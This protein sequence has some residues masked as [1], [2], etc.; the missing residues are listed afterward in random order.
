[1]PT[2]SPLTSEIK[3]VVV[4]G[5]TVTSHI[6]VSDISEDRVIFCVFPSTETEKGVLLL[7]ETAQIG[8]LHNILITNINDIILVETFIFTFRKCSGEII[9]TAALY[10]QLIFK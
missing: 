4:P 2:R 10:P 5:V 8:M 7:G 1:M 9:P 6:G 3:I